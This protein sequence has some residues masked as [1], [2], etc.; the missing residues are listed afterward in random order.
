LR[1]LAFVAGND[2][3]LEENKKARR[4]AGLLL[5][6]MAIAFSSEVETGSR[7]ENA[8]NKNESPVLI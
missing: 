6:R 4:N 5:V 2:G 1:K 8:S 7:K 3:N